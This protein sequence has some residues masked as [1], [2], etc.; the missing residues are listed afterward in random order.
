MKE[1][2]DDEA[3]ILPSLMSYRDIAIHDFVPPPAGAIEDRA[4]RRRRRRIV[5]GAAFA[6]ALI[7]AST[8][9]LVRAVPP[10]DR[11]ELISPSS[12]PA[13]TTSPA[14]P[15]SGPELIPTAVML[16][17]L[18]LWDSGAAVIDGEKGGWQLESLKPHCVNVPGAHPGSAPPRS[19]SR[20]RTLKKAGAQVWQ[21][22]HRSDE[23]RERLAMEQAREFLRWCPGVTIDGV[24]QP[25]QIIAEGFAGQESFI[26]RLAARNWVF[27]RDGELSTQILFQNGETLQE[28]RN[29]GRKAAR[30]FCHAFTPNC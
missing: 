2:K 11:Q 3:I 8:I 7:G 24:N 30:R 25:L 28:M 4:A 17:T 15:T 21:V 23:A 22:V 16:S 12:S 27:V 9:L 10:N 6:A 20:E 29:V 1:S 13:L 18:D 19:G 5:T 26:V 14:G